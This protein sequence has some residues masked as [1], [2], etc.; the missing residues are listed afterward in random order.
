MEEQKQWVRT[1]AV[2]LIGGK[3]MKQQ[4]SKPIG[5]KQ[6]NKQTDNRFMIIDNDVFYKCKHG[7]IFRMPHNYP[8]VG[9]LTNFVFY[10]HQPNEFIYL[11]KTDG[12]RTLLLIDENDIY[13]LN[14]YPNLSL[15]LLKTIE[16]TN[17]NLLRGMSLFDCE[18]YENNYYIFD[19][20]AVDNVL[21]Y[22]KTLTQRME[23]AREYI[24]K[25]HDNDLLNNIF[26]KQTYQVT[27]NNI[28]NIINLVNTKDYSPYTNHRIDG[29]VFQL[30]DK[31]YDDKTINSFKMKKRQLNTIDFKLKYDN[32]QN[33]YYLYLQD[34]LFRCPYAYNLHILNIDKLTE[35]WN[36]HGYNIEQQKQINNLISDMFTH[37]RNFDRKIVELSLTNSNYWVPMSVRHDKIFSNRYKVGI[38]NSGVIFSPLTLDETY[39]TK[40][41]DNSPFDIDIRSEYHDTNKEIRQY[42]FNKFFSQVEHKHP[43]SCLDLCGGRGAD[44]K[45]LIT[46]NVNDIYVIDGDKQALVQYV[47]RY[48]TKCKINACQYMFS[49]EDI[50]SDKL[51]KFIKHIQRYKQQFDIIVLNYALHY[52]VKYIDCLRQMTETLLKP[53]GYVLISFFDGDKLLK[54]LPIK[55]FEGIKPSEDEESC[56]MALPTIDPTGYREEPLVKQTHIEQLTNNQLKITDEFYPLEDLLIDHKELNNDVSDYLVNIKSIILQK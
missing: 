37:P 56:L 4:D 52:L 48:Y 26:V 51:N 34:K 54:S 53:N 10:Q 11:E 2:N 8:Q 25:C 30:N 35:S 12:E 3:Q 19:V 9:V 32:K 44:A 40:N 29:V 17:N 42:I 22:D 6:E 41:F 45:Y 36:S 20:Y 50:N 7:S 38:S 27:K 23:T 43:L 24:N 28:N 5:D 33:V 55:H 15:T 14:I 16:Q 31:P 13:K 46:N 21:V 18:L 1:T 39:F 49:D 47:E